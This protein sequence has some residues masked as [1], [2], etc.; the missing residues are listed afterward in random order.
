MAKTLV[1]FDWAMKRLLRQKSNFDILEGFLSELLKEDI[2]IEQ[3]L[4]SESNQEMAG[5]KFNRVDMLALNSKGQLIIIELQADSEKDY[6]YR[7]LFATSK[8]VVEHF[9]L[10]KEYHHIKKVYSVNIV[11]FD[12]GQGFDY[13]YHGTNTFRGIHNGDILALSQKQKDLYNKQKVHEIY[14]EYWIIKAGIFDEEK[15]N[16]KL[17]EWIY[18]LKTGEVQD[19]FTAPGLPEAK[20]RLDRLK[21]QPEERADYEAYLQRLMKIASYQETEIADAQDLIGQALEKKEMEHVMRLY[22]KHKSDEDIADL[23]EIST[24]RV[25]QIID[26]QNNK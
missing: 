10:G 15:V 3:I 1:R 24:E 23:L 19:D 13:V 21:L 8:A 22:N 20:I 9:Q 26:H 18:F 6:F 25:R 14:P 7:I 17:D 2:T 4:E 11:Y 12:L 5:L 16:D